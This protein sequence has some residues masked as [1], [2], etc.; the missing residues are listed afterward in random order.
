MNDSITTALVSFFC[1]VFLCHQLLLTSVPELLCEC[2]C[3]AVIFKGQHLEPLLMFFQGVSN[4]L[5]NGLYQMWVLRS[6]GN[7]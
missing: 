6:V 1:A 4:P 7:G 3:V 2:K 5:Q